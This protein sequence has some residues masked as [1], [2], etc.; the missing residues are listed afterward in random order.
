MLI[1]IF[2]YAY[3]SCEYVWGCVCVYVL[4]NTVC[5]D[6]NPRYG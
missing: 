3:F 1:D 6:R 2:V 5:R 4:I